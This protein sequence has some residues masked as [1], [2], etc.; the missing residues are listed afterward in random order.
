VAFPTPLT[1]IEPSGSLVYETT[2][3]GD[4]A[5]SGETDQFTITLDELQT[6]TLNVN[7]TGGG[8]LQPSVNFF[9]IP[10]GESPVLLGTASA[11]AA[12]QEAVLQTVQT[13]DQYADLPG[14]PLNYVAAV[15][16]A[17]GTTGTFEVTLTLNAAVEREA[18]DGAA[19]D[20]LPDAQNLNPAFR[21]FLP[22]TPPVA[23]QP[24]R[25]AVVGIADASP[26]LL[27]NEVE[28]NDSLGTAN[29]AARNF[30]AATG[31]NYQLA[32][33]G[34]IDSAGESDW[35]Q[36]GNLQPGDRLTAS[37]SGV[38][39]VRGTLDDPFVELYGGPAFSPILVNFN[40]DG[41]PG[42]D[43][44]LLNFS[45]PVEDTYYI[46][47][48]AFSD[49]TGTYDL[50]LWLE[51]T[52][53]P[54]RTGQNLTAESEPNNNALQADDA[55][56]SWRPVQYLSHTASAISPF[57]DVDHYG[58]SFTAGDVV[59]VQIRS[60]SAVEA[61]VT[62]LDAVGNP[63]AFEDGS[64][65]GTGSD[66]PL[67]SFLIPST[68]DYYVQVLGTNTGTYNTDVFLSTGTPPQQPDFG[69]DYYVFSLLAGESATLAV[70]GA[71]AH[72]QWFDAG[73]NPLA[74]GASGPTN[75]D[76][77]IS[78]I[79]ATS[80]GQYYVRV[81][82]AADSEYNLVVTRDAGFGLEPSNDISTA[83]IVQSS[84]L[85]GR[86]WML[87]ALDNE[88]D[89]SGSSGSVSLPVNRTDGTSFLWDILEDGSILNGTN[90]AYDGG[91]VH[92]G[93]PP[94]FSA[95]TEQDQRE[96]VIGPADLFG[97]SVTRKIFVPTDQGY[98]RFLEIV[99]NTGAAP[100]NYTVAIDTNLGSDS[101]T[102]L[103][104]TSSGDNNFDTDD[105]WIVTDDV[106][107]G[108]DPTMLHVTAGPGGAQ[109]PSSVFFDTSGF[110]FASYDLTLD[111]G[112][113][114][115]VMHFAAQNSN[116]ATA[117]AKGDQLAGLQ[118]NA[119]AGMSAVEIA[120]VVNFNIGDSDFYRV[121]VSAGQELQLQTFTPA[122]QAGEFVNNLD[123]ALRLYNA[124]GALVASDDNSAGD[125]R[126][127]KLSYVVPGPMARTYFVEV[128][129]SDTGLSGGE[130]VLQVGNASGG[131]L[132][133]QVT[134]ATPPDGTLFRFEP[135]VITIDFNDSV[136]LSSVEASDLTID[137]V[138]ADG[139]TVVDAN[140]INF[141]PP[142]GIWTEGPHDIAIAGGA[143]KDLQG[144]A[145]RAF[146][147]E[148]V[149]DYTA[150]RVNYSSVQHGDSLPAGD[151]TYTVGFNEEILEANLN[152]F[153]G[154]LY[155]VGTT[156]FYTAT[157]VS[158]DPV[159]SRLSFSFTDLPADTYAL[160]I[161][162]GHGNGRIED[163]AG[164]GLDGEPVWPIPPN[165]SGNGVEGGNFFLVFSLT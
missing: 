21:E 7:P 2:A 11:S 22:D 103:I 33:K 156:Q 44:L 77:A 39:S 102:Q 104:G 1:A 146:A 123:P 54:P 92:Q 25:A 58:Y 93:F 5:A 105:D 152:T 9:V 66:S 51:N 134:N 43:S 24:S 30:A 72:I 37:L 34:S 87:G 27:S 52:A 6:V 127:A 81:R 101:F 56:F 41:G 53:A 29:D 130:Y 42:F 31:A 90:D 112:E 18:H 68:G 135:A 19:N 111:P 150:P 50:G 17:G 40:D 13:A 155:G 116:Q 109:R 95:D 154:I 14:Q 35:Y 117:L 161:S 165:V 142:A 61:Q 108:S 12:G 137:G 122:G 139:F 153:A 125:G 128:A 86:R 121:F 132:P 55:T 49:G 99:T 88:A 144:V 94:F 45:V 3:T 79:V 15:T 32:L 75:A 82:G 67:Y 160:T 36:I 106:D 78:D 84:A 48:R 138:P 97:L 23:S 46:R 83:Q 63:L 120:A 28:P 96:I 64:S 164:W 20:T 159:L 136:L 162:S 85:S 4:I 26:G 80:T 163:L 70:Q 98:A 57:G 62:L 119:L 47:A 131:R 76:E 107:G 151:L 158:Y 110:L 147:A 145:L 140:T 60:T 115:I 65:D 38:D 129:A 143:I 10:T 71:D 118:L 141:I 157:N 126:N 133:F 113:T 124:Q 59:T 100:T 74:L 73:G 148:Y 69:Y 114:K 89:E 91:L 16:G 149:A 8:T